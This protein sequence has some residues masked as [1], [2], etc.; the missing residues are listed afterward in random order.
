MT[1]SMHVALE[2]LGLHA[3]YVVYPGTE[4]YRLHKKVE[5]LPLTELTKLRW[6]S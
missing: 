6:N 1:R 2:D 5:V 3:L 4:R